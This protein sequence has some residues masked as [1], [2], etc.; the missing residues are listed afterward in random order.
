MFGTCRTACTTCSSSSGWTSLRAWAASLWAASSRACSS[1]PQ[2]F[3]YL[4]GWGAGNGAHSLLPEWQRQ[5]LWGRSHS[6]RRALSKWAFFRGVKERLLWRG[7]GGG[8]RGA[9]VRVGRHE[10]AVFQRVR[11][12]ETG[13]FREA[14]I[15]FASIDADSGQLDDGGRRGERL[16]W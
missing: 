12:G 5:F 13:E 1:S 4:V 8:C 11:S 7:A 15:D 10:D 6:L 2:Y 16:R 3:L 9:P 14:A